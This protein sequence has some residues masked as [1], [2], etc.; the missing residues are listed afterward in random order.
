M[1]DYL[2]P[3]MD[4]ATLARKI[5]DLDCGFDILIKEAD[6]RFDHEARQ[7]VETQRTR[8]LAPLREQY[9]TMTRQ[10]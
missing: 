10:A 5:A 4:A 7:R 3:D 8:V 6:A 1:S 9:A 2:L